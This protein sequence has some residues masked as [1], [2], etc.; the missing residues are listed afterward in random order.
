MDDLRFWCSDVWA[1][2][3]TGWILFNTPEGKLRFFSL[4]WRTL[5]LYIFLLFDLFVVFAF[6]QACLIQE[7]AFPF[8]Y[9]LLV[10]GVL[11]S[12]PISAILSIFDLSNFVREKRLLKINI[13]MANPI[14]LFI[15]TPIRLAR[16]MITL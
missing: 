6:I 8:L 11:A 13:H 14:T 9:E 1:N 2:L 16:N 10:M 12:I 15:L 3:M 5:I 7:A 4:F